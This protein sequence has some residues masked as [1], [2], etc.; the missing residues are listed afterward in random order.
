MVGTAMTSR[1]S[2]TLS[3]YTKTRRLLLAAASLGLV[4]VAGCDDYGSDPDSNSNCNLPPALSCTDCHGNP[5]TGDPAPPRDA[6]DRTATTEIG[7]GAHQ[8]H[9]QAGSWRRDLSCEEC[10]AVPTAVSDPR[11]I[12]GGPAELTWGLLASTGDASPLWNRAAATCEGV[13][14]HGAT[15]GGGSNTSPLWTQVDGSQ[16]ACGTCHA[17]PPPAPHSASTRCA[18]CHGAVVDANRNFVNPALHINGQVEVAYAGCSACHGSETNAAPP[19][20]TLGQSDP[21]LVTVGA[22]QA[23]LA[24]ASWRRAVECDDCHQVPGTVDAPGHLDA[25][26]A[27]VTFS[28]LAQQGGGNP[29]FERTATTCS[30]VYCHGVTLAGPISGG[31]VSRTPLWTVVDGTYSECGTTCHTLPP[32]GG[33][34]TNTQCQQCHG[35]TLGSFNAADPAASTFSNPANHV[36]GVVNF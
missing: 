10:H 34:T 26:P 27:E 12:D 7:V 4:L 24:A 35:S 5:D 33:H 29:T 11:H 1:S 18:D 20:D 9:L 15:L 36:N 13:Y 6:Q 21:S 30:G 19:T 32:G 14:C 28:A 3:C 17:L 22:H 16:A 31:T 2:A 25:G 8:A 23:H